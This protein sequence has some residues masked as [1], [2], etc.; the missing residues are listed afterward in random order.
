MGDCVTRSLGIDPGL[1]GAL[2][3][4]IDGTVFVYDVP[5]GEVRG[6]RNLAI[7]DVLAI[8]ADWGESYGSLPCA[9][10]QVWAMPRQGVSSMFRFGEVYGGLQVAAVATGHQLHRVTPAE[11]KRTL[12]IP[13]GKD[14]ARLMAQERWPSQAQLFA[15]K[16][17]D[18]R[19]EAALLAL[20]M[21]EVW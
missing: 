14:A 13:K 8:L 1:S 20:W 3:A 5:V 19:A 9:I 17:D 6:K 10:E 7:P 11:W 2:A 21:Q 18:G 16:K 4:L 12:H 15:R